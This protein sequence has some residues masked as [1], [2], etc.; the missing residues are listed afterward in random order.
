M[1]PTSLWLALL[2]G[3]ALA[4]ATPPARL[5]GAEF[6]VLVGLMVWFAV[7]S[8]EL[9]RPAWTSY[10]LG[11]VHMACFSWSVRHVMFGAY[12]AI[13][14]LGGL[15]FVIGTW[16]VRA[17]PRRLAVPAFGV[18]VAVAYWL[19]A[20]MPEIC[21]PHG[22]PCHALWQ[23]PQLLGAVVL[24]GEPLANALLAVLA[25]AAVQAWRS[26]RVGAPRWS[27]ASAWCLGG[28]GAFALASVAGAAVRRAAAP[29]V[30][31]RLRVAAVEPGFHPILD[32]PAD[33]YA[34][35]ARSFDRFVQE[36]LVQPTRAQLRDGE[37][38]DLVL[39][40]ES[41]LREDLPRD[42]VLAGRI[43]LPLR[44]PSAAPTRLLLGAN[45]KQSD[46]HSTPAAVLVDVATGAVLGHQEKRHL[47]PGGEFPPLLHSLP[48]AVGAWLR[49]QFAAALRSLPDATP[50]VELPPLQTA[51]GV[52]FGALLCYDNAFPDVAAAQVAAGARCLCVLSNEAWYRGG[53]ELP[54]LVAMSVVRA[55]ETATPVV[56][57]TQDGWTVAIGGD[58]RMLA[59]LPIH[60]APQP[61]ARILLVDLPLGSGRLPAMAW[62]RRV[63]GVAMAG[64]AGALLLHGLIRWAKLRAARTAS[65]AV[66]ETGDPGRA[67]GSGS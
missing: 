3:G 24:G 60:A 19:R 48:T 40:P 30:V 17:A 42:E 25:A 43:K 13:V 37:P 14:L 49:E 23:W 36:R 66:G 59:G 31:E 4:V 67:D 44:L 46:Q 11:C 58:G 6:A 2:G 5:P 61:S 56:R 38:I 55:L 45:V 64:L 47:V 39:W 16:I 8:G 1:K 65:R 63:A 54:Q 34:A 29:P 32:C 15:Y 26:W 57:C 10:L 21:Y 7:A 22:Q 12:T 18:G 62:W 51:A 52:P 27:M 20:E 33:S 35:W 28:V 53:A 9:R 41:V 50:G